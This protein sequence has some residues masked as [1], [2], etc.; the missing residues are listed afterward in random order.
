MRAPFMLMLCAT[1]LTACARPYRIG[2]HV[3]VEWGD[4]TSSLA[5]RDSSGSCTEGWVWEEDSIVLCD[6]TCIAVQADPLARVSVSLEC[7]NAAIDDIVR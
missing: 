4:G 1:M 3:L 6:Q 2:D 7:N 5:L